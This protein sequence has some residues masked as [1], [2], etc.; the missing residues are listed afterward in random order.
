[1]RTSE[2][3]EMKS[4]RTACGALLI[5]AVFSLT[6]IESAGSSPYSEAAD[7]YPASYVKTSEA[8]CGARSGKGLVHLRRGPVDPVSAGSPAPEAGFSGQKI[9]AVVFSEEFPLKVVRS[10][11]DGDL[12]FLEKIPENCFLVKASDEGY[13][14][15]KRIKGYT[16]SFTPAAEDK[17]DPSLL[18]EGWKEPV[19]VEAI[20]ARGEGPA[21]LQAATGRESFIALMGEA[22][23]G[24]RMRW[25]VKAGN[26]KRFALEL[27]AFEEVV[28]VSPFFLPRPLNDD[29]VWV[30]QSYDTINKR[31]YA[32]SATL[33]S[34]GILGGGETAGIADSGMDNDMCYFS[35]GPDGFAIASYPQPPDPGPLDQSKKVV[36]YS[37][38]PGASAYDNNVICGSWI[39]F[40]GT[41]TAG[42][43]AG[44]SYFNLASESD[45]GHDGGDGMAPMAK[46]Y[47]QD[48][49]DDTSGCLTGLANDYSDIFSQACNAGVRV[50]SNS[51]GS[52]SGSVYSAE[53]SSVDGFLYN[54]EDFSLFFAAGNTGPMGNAIDSPATAK[55][56]VTVG[57]VVSGSY[58]ANMVS[59]FSSRGPTDD[60]RIKPDIMAPGENINS[61]S[62]T[63]SSTDGNCTMKFMSGT[64]MATPTAAGGAILLRNYFTKGFYP[65]G[66]AN[67]SDAFSPSS[68]LVKAA[69]IAGAM[70]VGSA[71]IPNVIEGWGRVNLDRFAYFS[72]GEKN[73]LR[74][75]AYDVRNECGL[76]DG[77]EMVFRID[78]DR[79]GPLKIVLAW[80]DPEGS[81]MS[82]V[83]LVNDLDLEIV[84]PSGA[85]YHGNNFSSGESVPSGQQDRRNNIE[86]FYLSSAGEGAWQ[87][88]V[89][90]F[91]VNGTPREDGSDIQGFALAV[92]KPAGA[93]PGTA[94]AGLAAEDGGTAGITLSW[95][96]VPG[97]SSYSVYRVKGDGGYPDSPV[98]FIGSSESP[99]FRDTKAQGGYLYTYFVR[100]AAG[101]FEGPASGRA[102]ATSSGKC[103][104]RPEFS[105][106][107]SAASNGATPECDIV[108]GWDAASSRCPLEEEVSYN[109]Y[110]GAAPDFEPSAET[111][112]ASG[113]R[114]LSF[115]DTGMA[116]GKTSY[117]VVRSE[118]SGSSGGG[119]ANG[120]NEDRNLKRINGTPF[121]EPAGTGDWSDDGGDTYALM[122]M[123]EPWS[124]SSSTNHTP[125]GKYCYGIAEKGLPYPSNSCG[126]LTTPFVEL[127]GDSPKLSYSVSYDVENC[128]D[129]VVVE[130]SEDG[131]DFTAIT[132]A[133][134][135]PGSF[136]YTGNPPINRCGFAASQGAFSGPKANDGLTPWAL[137]SHD[138]SAFKGKSVK[139]RWRFSSDPASEYEGFYIDD[140]KIT[141]VNIP[142]D[143][144]GALPTVTL[145][146]ASYSC[147]DELTVRVFDAKKKGAG[148]REILLSSA[149]EPVPEIIE[150]SEE[151]PSSGYFYGSAST[152]S[153][154]P[155]VNGKLSVK[156]GDAILAS[157]SG[158]S[159]PVEG[160][161]LADCSAPSV[162]SSSAGWLSATSVV[163]SFTADE[164]VTALIRYGLAGGSDHVI[165][166]DLLSASHRVEIAGLQACSEYGL[167]ITVT[168][169]AGNSRTRQMSPFSTRGCY[170]APQVTAV[171]KMSDPF[172]LVV[173]GTGFASDSRVKIN[174]V[175]APETIFRSPA[176]VIAKKGPQLKA[177]LPKG[178]AVEITV[179]NPS[180]MTE[181]E[182]FPF[183]R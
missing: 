82:S 135:Y 179:V 75:A 60:G 89:R 120:G 23:K 100:A 160:S 172:R 146:R 49:G 13:R 166:D 83:A 29:S 103:V 134:G 2:G 165:A 70:D 67:A 62:G 21:R 20:L 42:T 104:L 129:G 93:S 167:E 102:S 35:Y 52:A 143:C 63:I 91:D 50:H 125:Y 121:G 174:G 127:K 28:S 90:A 59:D 144:E 159:G 65:G 1:M 152:E 182:P 132:P 110:R 66:E 14:K 32:L 10:L 3:A 81:P 173:S 19:V 55:N 6:A 5:S 61:A 161:A 48:V 157:Y 180:D 153:A 38:L 7:K 88:R 51:W 178:V 45:P 41:H 95:S 151:P 183:R 84:S 176:K 158:G 156:D 115:T 107:K 112:V 163:I 74:C 148:K 96:A 98:A 171:K 31:N 79:S 137:F 150:G 118:D 168:D 47:F 8:S 36:G 71:D 114:G 113:V 155:S 108:L 124:V 128:W 162:V 73:G 54:H 154:P 101:G 99:G 25:L 15:L 87:V 136:A 77:E 40:H 140:I 122:T 131:S 170:P 142:A 105:G 64:S 46:I 119:P 37:V 80:L 181:S 164:P 30:I 145:D 133:E 26:V 72:S 68:S 27:A 147:S 149:S 69:L 16:C 9:F 56:C 141:G 76:A 34:H 53:A 18:S 85:V 58:G 78:M 4:I 138:L 97:A 116:P 106:V 92:I 126:S 22:E 12:V 17:V 86:G 24:Y 169:I 123:D 111:L 43:L 39:N 117:Y 57:S 44:D 175:P 130:L 33:F 109:V 11:E 94:P 139:V 177:L